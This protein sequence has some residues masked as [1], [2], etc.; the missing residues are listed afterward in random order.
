MPLGTILRL[1]ASAAVA[2]TG[3]RTPC[4]LID[5][6]RA[7]LRRHVIRPDRANRASDVACW[8]WSRRVVKSQQA[9]RRVCCCRTDPDG[10]SRLC[11]DSSNAPNIGSG[12]PTFSDG[13]RARTSEHNEYSLQTTCSSQARRLSTR[14]AHALPRPFGRVDSVVRFGFGALVAG[15]FG[16][17]HSRA[18]ISS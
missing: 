18:S 2:L 3:L 7:G 5:R 11:S 4:V 9:T 8:A 16:I 6:H 10:P 13:P 12:L 15:G 1:G 17:L 14:P